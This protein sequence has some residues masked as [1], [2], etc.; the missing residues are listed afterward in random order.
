MSEDDS[1]QC[2]SV[3]CDAVDVLV[4]LVYLSFALVDGLAQLG[5][6]GE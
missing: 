6:A 1:G 2:F 5:S 4:Y 3:G